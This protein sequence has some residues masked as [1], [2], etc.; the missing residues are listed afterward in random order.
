MFYNIKKLLSKVKFK[1]LAT[2]IEKTSANPA[3][4]QKYCW[5]KHFHAIVQNASILQQIYGSNIKN[6]VLVEQYLYLLTN[7][8]YCRY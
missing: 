1:K 4:C 5:T 3:N 6:R 8:T 7:T 2:K